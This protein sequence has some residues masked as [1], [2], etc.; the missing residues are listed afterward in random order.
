MLY[1]ELTL[2]IDHIPT[3]LE[4]EQVKRQVQ[5]LRSTEIL[6]NLPIYRFEPQRLTLGCL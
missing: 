2:S 1:Y 5:R 3:N 6:G 4:A